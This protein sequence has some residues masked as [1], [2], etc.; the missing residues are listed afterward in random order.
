MLSISYRKASGVALKSPY[1]VWSMRFENKTKIW[2]WTTCHAFAGGAFVHQAPPIYLH[3]NV[4]LNWTW[5]PICKVCEE[6]PKL[7]TLYEQWF[8]IVVNWPTS[9]TLF[10]RIR[11]LTTQGTLL[12]H[13]S[14]PTTLNVQAKTGANTVPYPW[15]PRHHSAASRCLPASCSGHQWLVRSVRN[16]IFR[17]RRNYTHAG[18]VRD[19]VSCVEPFHCIQGRGGHADVTGGTARKAE[20]KTRMV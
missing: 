17:Q 7:S 16:R 19:P 1:S 12:C 9:G 2:K 8:A 5:H 14:V 18:G 6:C 13:Y 11:D 3:C 10:R 4:L 20:Y 15:F